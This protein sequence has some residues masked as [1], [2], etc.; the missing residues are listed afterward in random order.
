MR[1]YVLYRRC[2]TAE[3]K[4]SGLGLEAQ[5]RDI[6]LFLNSAE[7]PGEVI[8]TFEDVG[9]GADNGRPQLQAA[10]ELTRK[11]GAELLA[12]KVDRLSR[13]VSHLAALLDDPKVKIRVASMPHADKFAL[14]IYSALA[15]QE[16]HFISMRTRAA[17][18]AAKARGKRLGGDRGNLAARNAA[19]KAKADEAARKVIDVIGPMRA[20]GASLQAIAD[21]LTTMGVGSNWS[22]MKV[23]RALNRMASN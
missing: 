22:A 14:H 11:T 17:L 23:A 16:R 2:S 9:S 1:Q 5:Q 15:E 21:K 20:Q 12:S 8:A 3:Q 6:D 19:K 7:E 10:I 13:R 4:K 18:Q